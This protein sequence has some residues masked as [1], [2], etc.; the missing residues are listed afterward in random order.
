MTVLRALVYAAILAP[1]SAATNPRAAFQQ[2]CNNRTGRHSGY[3][4]TFWKS[5]GDACMPLEAKGSYTSQYRLAAR[6][7][8]VLGKGWRTGSLKRKI[9]YRA[10]SFEP[11]SNS[12][13]TLYGWSTNPLIEYYVVES[14]GSDFTPPGQGTPLL[15]TVISDGGTYNIYRTR[16]V[17][18]P[19]I[20]GT[21]TFYQYW[22]VRTSKRPIGPEAKIEVDERIDGALGTAGITR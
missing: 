15:G 19:S 3:F 16:R 12:Y 8:L 10:A 22:S 4:Y 17:R 21:A 18:Q 9:G 1:L 14:W 13:L 20:R 11:G 7:N 2:G 5:D 6:E